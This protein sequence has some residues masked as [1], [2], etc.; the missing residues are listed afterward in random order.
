MVVSC[1]ECSPWW[2]RCVGRRVV[3]LV[4]GG[5]VRRGVASVLLT[6]D[7]AVGFAFAHGQA[8]C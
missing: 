2:S 6:L 1:L 5:F 8:R 3:G 7:V 4:A